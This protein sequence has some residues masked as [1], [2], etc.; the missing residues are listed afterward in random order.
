MYIDIITVNTQTGQTR[1]RDSSRTGTTGVSVAIQFSSV[2]SSV[3]R[4]GTQ[5]CLP[6]QLACS[7]ARSTAL[8]YHSVTA[9]SCF[10]YLRQQSVLGYSPSWL[11]LSIRLLLP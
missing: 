4:L 3:S 9:V 11:V 5:L 10:L 7:P 2:F 6:H 1:P 8:S